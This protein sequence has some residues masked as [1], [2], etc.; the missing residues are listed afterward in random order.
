[1]EPEEIETL[2]VLGAGSMGHGIAEVAALAGYEVTLRDIEREFVEDGYE[3]IVWSLEKL[4][5]GGRIEEAEAEAARDRITPLVDLEAAVEG[6]DVVVEAVPERMDV[7]KEVYTEVEEYL[8]EGAIVASN[9]SSLSITELSEVT[10]RPGR[11]CGMHFFNPP[12]R[13]EL[14]EVISGAHTEE[15]T[16]ETVEAFAESLGKTPVRVR[17]D[18]PGFIVNRVLVPLMN[19]ASYLVSDDEATVEAVDST[20]KFDVG[21]P[22][23]LFELADLTGNDVNH[24]VLEYMH[25]VLGEAYEPA[26]LLEAKV[27]NGELGKKTGTGFYEYEDSQGAEIPADA[28]SDGVERRLLAAMANEVGK[29]VAD[30]VSTPDDIDRAVLLG[31]GFPEGPARMADDH[32]LVDLVDLLEERYEAT[33]HPRFEVGEGLREAADRGGFH[34]T[35]DG[36]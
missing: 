20:A 18:S 23:G 34:G 32:G 24:S 12:V 9:T 7:K 8:P 29:L 36:R 25:E 14:V 21:L 13:M 17:K 4:A 28:G 15:A 10:D 1:M 26:P 6:A 5:D 31:A 19:E 2:A 35:D 22:M 30:D 27:E 33:G 11:F 16:L 3:Q